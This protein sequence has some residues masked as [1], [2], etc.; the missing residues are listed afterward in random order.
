MVNANKADEYQVEVAPY[1]NV[2]K[3]LKFT[4]EQQKFVEV[5]PYWNVNLI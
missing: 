4:D 5:A 2:N 1:W 3:E